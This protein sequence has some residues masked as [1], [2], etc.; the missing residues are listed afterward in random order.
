MDDDTENLWAHS[1]AIQQVRIHY[2]LEEHFALVRA[3]RVKPWWRMKVAAAVI[4]AAGTAFLLCRAFLPSERCLYV[5]PVE[6]TAMS[7]EDVELCKARYASDQSFAH[8]VDTAFM[9]YEPGS[10]ENPGAAIKVLEASAEEGVGHRLHAGDRVWRHELVQTSGKMRFAVGDGFEVTI[11]GPAKV[12]L[13]DAETIEISSG[14]V[15]LD[16]RKRI[17]VCVSGRHVA[18]AQASVGV[19]VRQDKPSSDLLVTDGVVLIDGGICLKPCDG[20]RIEADGSLQ[21]Y[22]SLNDSASL[23]EALLAGVSDIRITKRRHYAF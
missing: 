16:V 4:L 23:R 17:G 1:D 10:I 6:A 22:R 15:L 7:A 13:P 21:R 2:M 14:N 9:K 12:R 19:V 3:A 5:E 8:S 18:V 20:V 11:L